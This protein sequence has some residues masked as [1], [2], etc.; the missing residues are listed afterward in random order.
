MWSLAILADLIEAH[1]GPIAPNVVRLELHLDPPFR[2]GESE[3]EGS[4]DEV[5]ESERSQDDLWVRTLRLFPLPSLKSALI[6]QADSSNLGT[7]RCAWALAKQSP[8]LQ[9]LDL[10]VPSFSFAYGTTFPTLTS[11]MIDGHIDYKAWKSLAACPTLW[12]ISLHEATDPDLCLDL[13]IG[14][15]EG[16][17]I[18]L[19]QLEELEIYDP[20]QCRDGEFIT[21][22]VCNTTMPLLL[23]ADISTT[24]YID[25]TAICRALATGSPL[26]KKFRLNEVEIPPGEIRYGRCK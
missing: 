9:H 15:H 13:W 23:E 25:G 10:Y 2:G 24:R 5:T 18:T 19:P 7:A 16:Y 6:S 1:G 17:E 8:R 20:D 3:G 26:L 21:S 4:F 12:R 14:S 11:I 22:I